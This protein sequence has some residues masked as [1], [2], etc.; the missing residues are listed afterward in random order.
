MSILSKAG[1]FIR[2]HQRWL[3]V[4]LLFFFSIANNLDRWTLSILAPTLKE[5]LGFT[6]VEYSYIVNGFLAAYA[7][8][9]VFCGRLLDRFGVKK[10]MAVA[11][12]VWSLVAMFHA[13]AAGWVSLFVFRF[14]L[15]LFESF[16]SPGG[17]K[18]LSE[19]TPSRERGLCVA[20]FNNGYVWGSII[21][22]PLVAFLALRFS[23]HFGFFVPGLAGFLLFAVWLKFYD[24]PERHK[25]IT[26]GERTHILATRGGGAAS[27][28]K[29]PFLKLLTHPL[30]IA[31][32]FARFLTDPYSY[33]FNFWLPDYFANE[34]GFSLALIGLIGWI[35]FLGAD[36]GGP[37]GGA[38]SDWLVRRGFA[39]V[40][41]RFA[42]LAVAALLAPVASIVVR[43][44]VTWLCI[45]LIGMMIVAQTCWMANQLSLLSES[46]PRNAV[47]TVVAISAIGG[48]LGGILATHLTGQIVHRY[49]YMPVFTG[50][51][52]LHLTALAI[53]GSVLFFTGR[54]SASS[55]TA[56]TA[57]P[58]TSQ[59]KETL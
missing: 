26:P 20:I 42:L 2:S 29:I 46:F 55:R 13:A 53:V 25:T 22:V 21:A 59:K 8:G 24:S 31:F 32:F 38:T 56:T 44:D 30:C 3:I 7:I 18:A 45:A 54:L 27:G 19:W 23:W 17:I 11:L 15:G 28:E 49:G 12:A 52:V 9:Y 36:I 41:A 39:P 35:P 4:V 34:R 57:F 37:G 6:S 58:G 10:C 51:S 14:M 1:A 50:I 47:A 43:T 16:N 48:S 5:K 33:F 40:R